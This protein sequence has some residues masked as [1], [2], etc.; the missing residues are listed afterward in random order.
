M[1]PS[2]QKVLRDK[3]VVECI[4]L[5]GEGSLGLAQH[6][7]PGTYHSVWRTAGV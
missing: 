4:Q 3:T 1:F 2:G 5:K 6:C 7:N